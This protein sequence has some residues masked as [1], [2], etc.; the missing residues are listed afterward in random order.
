MVGDYKARHFVVS[1]YINLIRFRETGTLIQ[2]RIEE[3]SRHFGIKTVFII[4]EK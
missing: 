3:T 1:E 4:S 2:N